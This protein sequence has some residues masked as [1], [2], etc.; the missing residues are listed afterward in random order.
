MTVRKYEDCVLALIQDHSEESDQPQELPHPASFT[1]YTPCIQPAFESSASRT[2]LKTVL[3][4]ICVDVIF[5][6]HIWK[7]YFL[8]GK[9]GQ[10]GG[11]GGDENNDDD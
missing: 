6:D 3:S 2:P 11:G 5:M 8:F 4:T 1:P 7:D 10:C 9:H